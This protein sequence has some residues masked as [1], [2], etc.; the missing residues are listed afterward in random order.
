MLS[1]VQLLIGLAHHSFA[2]A[3]AVKRCQPVRKLPK[4]RILGFNPEVIALSQG[5]GRPSSRGW[6]PD[7]GQNGAGLLRCQGL[8]VISHAQI[9][10]A[11]IVAMEGSV[12]ADRVRARWQ[13]APQWPLLRIGRSGVR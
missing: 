13:L 5:L 3:T 7:V 9:V 8:I 12:I 4:L 11:R 6:I 1:G 10:A 2:D